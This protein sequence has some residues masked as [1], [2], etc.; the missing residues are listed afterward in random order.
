M[1][2]ILLIIVMCLFFS[3]FIQGQTVKYINIS[4]NDWLP[5][6]SEDMCINGMSF[7]LGD[8]Y[9]ANVNFPVN[10]GTV[11]NLGVCFQD[12][13]TANIIFTLIRHDMKTET[14]EDVFTVESGLHEAPGKTSKLSNTLIT[15]GADII[16]NSRYTWYI[17]V[18]TSHDDNLLRFFYLRIA[19][20]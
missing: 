13:T 7:G 12:Y 10:T 15:P 18:T 14:A 9:Y 8:R 5:G 11:R 2:K 16:N 6:Q 3:F 4:A 19:Y 1:K 17:K 20:Q